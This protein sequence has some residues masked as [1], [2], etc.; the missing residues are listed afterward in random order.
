MGRLVGR[1]YTGEKEQALLGF[2]LGA[3][4]PP[5][6]LLG[7]LAVCCNCSAGQGEEGGPGRHMLGA[8]LLRGQRGEG[9]EP[10]PGGEKRG[11]SLPGPSAPRWPMGGW[12]SRWAQGR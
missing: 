6:S 4:D 3:G 9:V 10:L 12:G 11:C 7:S 2:H 1:G 8:Q 5:N